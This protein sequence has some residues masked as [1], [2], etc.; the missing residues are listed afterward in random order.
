MNVLLPKVAFDSAAA[1]I[2][3][4]ISSFLTTMLLS[5]TTLCF[6]LF[7]CTFCCRSD[8]AADNTQ[9]TVV[10]ASTLPIS[11]ASHTVSEAEVKS[12][13]I[14][15]PPQPTTSHEMFAVQNPALLHG[16]YGA[17]QMAN[18]GGGGGGRFQTAAVDGQFPALHSSHGAVGHRFQTPSECSTAAEAAYRPILGVHQPAAPARHFHPNEGPVAQTTADLFQPDVARFHAAGVNRFS[19]GMEPFRGRLPDAAVVVNGERFQFLHPSR[20]LSNGGDRFHPVPAH[21]GDDCI[22]GRFQLAAIGDSVPGG[23]VTT[24]STNGPLGGVYHCHRDFDSSLYAASKRPRLA[25][26]DWL[27]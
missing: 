12:E 7:I 5:C 14:S 21:I 2:E 6:R 18:G 11:C 9:P 13:P 19:L 22:A 4:A 17:A 15:P 25:T 8:T 26:D 3:P 16:H 10:S 1:T 27:C 20:Y 23:A 24:P